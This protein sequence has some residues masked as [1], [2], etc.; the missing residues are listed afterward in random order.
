LRKGEAK[1]LKKPYMTTLFLSVFTWRQA[2]SQYT[3]VLHWWIIANAL[4]VSQN[5]AI[6]ISFSS[7]GLFLTLQLQKILRER[8]GSEEKGL[9][10]DSFQHVAVVGHTQE[11]TTL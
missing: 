6:F 7:P 2:R 1:A 8:E 5:K 9:A 3:P 11:G 4:K 10:C